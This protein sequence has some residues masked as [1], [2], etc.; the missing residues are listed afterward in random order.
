LEF[1]AWLESNSLAGRN[2]NL[3]A[4]AGVPANAGLAR[5]DIE[6]AKTAKLNAFPA[7]EG[8]LHAL[9]HGFDRHLGF[10]FRDTG[11]IDNFVDD[12]GFYQETLLGRPAA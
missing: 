7:A 5:A 6:D 10:R 8:S 12:I 2:R 4:R 1:L 11:A 9:E 3:G